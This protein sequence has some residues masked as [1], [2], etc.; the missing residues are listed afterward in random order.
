[1]AH[2]AMSTM[3]TIDTPRGEVF[4]YPQGILLLLLRVPLFLYRMGLG[5]VVNA[6]RIMILTTRGRKSGLPR[7]TALEYRMH[8]NKLYVIS[9]WGK[10][11]HWVKNL[12]TDPLVTLQLG[13]RVYAAHASVVDT[14]GEALRALH[15]F[16]RSNPAYYDTVLARMS[17]AGAVDVNTLP[18]ISS[19]FTI[20]RLD[21]LEGMASLPL[22]RADLTWILPT[23]FFTTL[24]TA[25][26]LFT[27]SRVRRS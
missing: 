5:E 9:G 15:L 8:G 1:M 7:H 23:G 14:P 18:Q 20:V 25:A 27:L 4:T 24:A 17:D 6:A 26:L 16:R 3:T 22:L 10:R 12:L 19:Q 13:S 21:R 11:P 2:H